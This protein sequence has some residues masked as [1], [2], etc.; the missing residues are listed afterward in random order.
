MMTK[1]DMLNYI[2]AKAGAVRQRFM[3]TSPGQE[4]T[5]LLKIEQAKAYAIANFTGPVP[6]LVQSEATATGKDAQ[7]SALAIMGQQS[8]WS[9][10]A[11]AIESV[12]R[13]GKEGVAKATTDEQALAVFDATVTGLANIMAMAG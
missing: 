4:A 12:R 11:G 2:D 6:S 10:L 1:T 9:Q 5:Y 8:Q 7:T 3:T 13:S